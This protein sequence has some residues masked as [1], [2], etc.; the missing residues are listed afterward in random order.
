MCGH[1]CAY[2]TRHCLEALEIFWELG[3]ERTMMVRAGDTEL[4]GSRMLA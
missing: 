4:S 3:E 2:I 1:M